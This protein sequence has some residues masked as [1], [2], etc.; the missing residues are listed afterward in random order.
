MSQ[1]PYKDYSN[2]DAVD[3]LHQVSALYMSTKT[4]HDYGTGDVYTVVEVHTL[5]YI[6][7]N[8]G[9]TV[10]QLARDNGKTKGAVSQI[11]K[12]LENKG[13]VFRVAD[14]E[15]DKRNH[16]FL[17]EKGKQLDEA[18][19]NYDAGHFGESMDIVRKKFTKEEINTTF[20]VLENWLEVRREVQQRRIWE[21]K[22]QERQKRREVMKQAN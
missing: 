15:N 9:I 5:K 16:L 12:K 8:H 18:H 14:P 4:Q 11:L 7:D 20:A 22:L 13:L 3:I 1:G 2:I 21:K 10:T 19:R 17:T 6:A